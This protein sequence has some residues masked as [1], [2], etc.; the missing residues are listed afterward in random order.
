[1]STPEEHPP[2]APLEQTEGRI[3]FESTHELG[4]LG[5]RC[6]IDALSSEC[7]DIQR[8]EKLLEN[9]LQNIPADS[10]QGVDNRDYRRVLLHQFELIALEHP[11]MLENDD[12][13]EKI[14]LLVRA[15]KKLDPQ[16]DNR[17]PTEHP[18]FSLW[19]F[20]NL[21]DEGTED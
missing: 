1:M 16:P 18:F 7:A 3:S 11:E 13:E 20:F 19:N 2:T 21:F 8:Q 12:L 14:L 6:E 10:F 17:P 9:F 15:Y 4:Y 5:S